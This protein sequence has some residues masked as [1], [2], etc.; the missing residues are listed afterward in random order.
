MNLLK[1]FNKKPKNKDKST[2]EKP[3]LT[4]EPILELKINVPRAIEAHRRAIGK[5]AELKAIIEAL[6]TEVAY[7]NSEIAV[8]NTILEGEFPSD[9]GG[10]IG[11]IVEIPQ[12]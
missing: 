9:V 8:L 11:G 7:L 3:R 2:K 1:L 12:A 10:S 5:I 4:T 6:D